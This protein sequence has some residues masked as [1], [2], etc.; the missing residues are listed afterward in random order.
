[1]GL[2]PGLA[3]HSPE[4]LQHGP[5]RAGKGLGFRAF[6]GFQGLGFRVYSRV[7]AIGCVRVIGL[8]RVMKLLGL[9]VRGFW[10][11]LV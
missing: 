4:D 6:R 1:M 5:H 10:C 9:S 7:F 2:R 11:A 3:R 8:I